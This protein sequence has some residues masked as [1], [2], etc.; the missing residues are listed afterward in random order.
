MKKE[1]KVTI[2]VSVVTI[3]T[4]ALGIINSEN[5]SDYFDLLTEQVNLTGEYI[6]L[7][8]SK[9]LAVVAL[10]DSEML[11]AKEEVIAVAEKRIAGILKKIKHWNLSIIGLTISLMIFQFLIIH[12]TAVGTGARF[13]RT[14]M[15]TALVILAVSFALAAIA[16]LLW[17]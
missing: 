1:S 16:G 3:L 13:A 8:I 5:N 11:L 15:T 2:I 17:I 7:L 14:W 6:D 12:I 10:P 4:L 9:R